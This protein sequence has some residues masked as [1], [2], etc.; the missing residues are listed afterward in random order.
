MASKFLT[1][2]TILVLFLSALGSSA[3]PLRRQANNCQTISTTSYTTT[4][5]ASP[6][7]TIT[8]VVPTF[9]AI[10]CGS[11]SGSGSSANGPVKRQANNCIT[12][13]TTSYITTDTSTPGCTVTYM[14]PEVTAVGCGTC[15]GSII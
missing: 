11:C 9:T 6:G 13:S 3:E 8:Y 14:A 2:I 12:T 10:G 15:A 1:F 5:T 4:N 7:C